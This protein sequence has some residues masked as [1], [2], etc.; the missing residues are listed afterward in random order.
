ML[1]WFFGGKKQLK[2]LLNELKEES[3]KEL[4]DIDIDAVYKRLQVIRQLI[5]D[6]KAEKTLK[7]QLIYQ[8]NQEKEKLYKKS[9]E[10]TKSLQITLSSIVKLTEKAEEDT[11]LLDDAIKE[12]RQQQAEQQKREL[13]QT[14]TELE[15]AI[16]D[17]EE[18]ADGI[19]RLAPIPNIY[20][21]QNFKLKLK[22]KTFAQYVNY[23]E[24]LLIKMTN[25]DW[26]R[27][28]SEK[29]NIA[30]YFAFPQGHKKHQ[31]IRIIY[32]IENQ[33]IVVYDILTHDDY[34][35]TMGKGRNLPAYTGT[36]TPVIKPLS[37]FA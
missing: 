30:D 18:L 23:I 3:E 34:M 19:D 37:A 9:P 14:L 2:R 1:D 36:R 27:G 10:L 26:L 17:A 24:Q 20:C 35:R 29:L 33:N 25:T 5:T 11:L 7:Q 13:K 31:S 15:E 4:R 12:N 22:Q 8:F 28:N 32:G 16:Q 6:Q 21:T